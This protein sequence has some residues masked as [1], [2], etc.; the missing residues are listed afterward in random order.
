ML[1]WDLRQEN[2]V[3]NVESHVLEVNTKDFNPFNEYLLLTG[4][5]DK[6]SALWDLRNLKKIV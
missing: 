6:T 3:Y 1:I 5:N 2:P 4:S